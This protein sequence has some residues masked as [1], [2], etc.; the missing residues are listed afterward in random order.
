MKVSGKTSILFFIILV[1]IVYARELYVEYSP[2]GKK[3]ETRVIEI[4]SN[5]EYP[6]N[7]QIVSYEL[8]RRDMRRWITLQ[9]SSNLSHQEVLDFY[10]DL[11]RRKG[12]KKDIWYN[13]VKD[14]PPFYTYKIDDYHVSVHPLEGQLTQITIGLDY[15]WESKRGRTIF[16]SGAK[17]YG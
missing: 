10:D 13:K 8:D 3:Y 5:L 9:I 7:T 14:N 4:Y 1:L 6:P 11:F 17:E 16:L 2:E 15:N 12:A